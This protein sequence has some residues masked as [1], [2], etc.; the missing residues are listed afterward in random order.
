[1]KITKYILPLG[2]L[3]ALVACTST[4]VIP[5]IGDMQTVI[6]HAK[7]ENEAVKAANDQANRVC[8][9]LQNQK[10]KIIDL[11]TIYQ[12][13]DPNQK[14]LVSLA[15]KILPENKTSGPFV[16]ENYTY[17]ATLTFRCI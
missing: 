13:N 12:G 5:Q 11:D 3:I 2:L 10:L 15:K 6:A 9:T 14:S 17:K 16:P 4:T 1:M 8:T 7:T